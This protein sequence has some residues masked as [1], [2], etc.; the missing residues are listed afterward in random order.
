MSKAKEA[1]DPKHWF[2]QEYIGVAWK[3]HLK[4]KWKT[5]D[6]REGSSFSQKRHLAKNWERKFHPTPE[7]RNGVKQRQGKT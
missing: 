7:C 3:R 6:A 1:N 5:M 2:G 4:K